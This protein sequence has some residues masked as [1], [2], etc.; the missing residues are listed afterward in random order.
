VERVHVIASVDRRRDR[1]RNRF[2]RDTVHGPPEAGYARNQFG[3]GVAIGIDPDPDTDSD[4]E[5]MRCIY[6]AYPDRTI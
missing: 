1:Y 2:P 6:V 3:V 4:T 5:K